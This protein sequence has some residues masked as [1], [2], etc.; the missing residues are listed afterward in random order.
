MP[1]NFDARGLLPP[2]VHDATLDEVRDH[3]ARFQRS[4]RRVTLFDK[5]RGYLAELAKTG[6]ACQ[7]VIDGSFIMPAVDEPNDIDMIL[8][9]PADWDMTRDLR[10]FE[11]N[12][13]TN[14]Y[15]KRTFKVEV[16]PVAEGSARHRQ[17]LD[18]FAQVRREWCQ[19]F[20]WPE[21]TTKGLV[22]IVS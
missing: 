13:V 7:V 18:F 16:F 8:V 12:L 1:L 20:G 2:G 22:R 9:L 3:F 15:T 6:W 10:P 14:N 4:D 19:E 21:G 17:F 11:Y 5:L